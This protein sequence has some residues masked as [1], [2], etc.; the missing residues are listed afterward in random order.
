MTASESLTEALDQ[1]PR[2]P[3]QSGPTPIERLKNLSVDL[4]FE[5]SVKRDDCTTVLFGGNKVRQLEYYLGQA[6]QCS[7]DTVLI[8]GAVQSNFVRTTAAMAAKLGMGCHVQLEQRVDTNSDCYHLNGNAFLNRLLGAAVHHYPAGEDENGAD[9]ALDDLAENLRREGANPYVIHLGVDSPPIGALGYVAAA[10]E[11]AEQLR[12]I[13]PV[14]VIY[15]ASGSA[16]T[17]CGLLYGLRALGIDIAVCGVC[18]RREAELQ[19]K[20]VTARLKDIGELLLGPMS[21]RDVQLTDSTLAPGYGVMS[22]D[23]KCV[24]ETAARREGL[25]LDPVYSGKTLSAVFN[26]ADQLQGKHVLFWHTGGQA[27]VFAYRDAF[28]YT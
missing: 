1:F 25:M 6:Q 27:A 3:A 8:T 23:T 17:H 14:D 4:G 20:R 13:E 5:L 12:H 7:A 19:R 11:C 10:I 22:D 24:I 9:R 15:I 21:D 2:V 16:L 18:V 26:D 28:G